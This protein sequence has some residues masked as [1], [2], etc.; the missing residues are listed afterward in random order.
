MAGT[1]TGKVGR[2]YQR[3]TNQGLEGTYIPG[4]HIVRVQGPAALVVARVLHQVPVRGRV[5]VVRMHHHQ[6]QT[7]GRRPVFWPTF[8]TVFWAVFR[9]VCVCGVDDGAFGLLRRGQGHGQGHGERA[10][11]GHH[12]RHDQRPAYTN[13]QNKRR[14]SE[15][16]AYAV[17]TRVSCH[18][19]HGTDWA[20]APAGKMP[21]CQ[22]WQGT[23]VVLNK[24]ITHRVAA[25]SAA[26]V[27]RC[28]V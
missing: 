26:A 5:Q 2:E 13:T 27:L 12:I 16:R 17:L 21:A 6:R 22:V 18:L 15:W 7:R 23:L 11:P 9:A 1:L 20:L 19:R 14:R 28:G 8:W 24:H 10:D 25:L 3:C 4:V